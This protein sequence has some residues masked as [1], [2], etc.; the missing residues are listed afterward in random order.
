M[1]FYAWESGLKT[2]M[3]YL[4]TKSAVDAKKFTLSAEKK[5]VSIPANAQQQQQVAA[6]AAQKLEA[7]QQPTPVPTPAQPTINSGIVNASEMQVQM[8]LEVPAQS[9]QAQQMSSST[10]AQASPAPQAVNAAPMTAEEM[11]QII[12]QAKASQGDD[13]CLMCGS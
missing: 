10:N 7:R 4:R 3:Y 8:S 6:R 2:G 9:Y 5:E 12:A 11:Q 13:D 1:H